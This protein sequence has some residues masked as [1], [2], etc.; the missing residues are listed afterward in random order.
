MDVN[1]L[2]LIG[3]IVRLILV[4]KFNLKKQQEAS[5][6]NFEKEESKDIMAG[7]IAII[8]LIIWGVLAYII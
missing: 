7:S 3:S 2:G 4:F 5:D 6:K 1:F 8:I